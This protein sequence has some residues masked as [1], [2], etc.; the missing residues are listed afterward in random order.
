MRKRFWLG[1][2]GK[3]FSHKKTLLRQGN[4]PWAGGGGGTAPCKPYRYVPLQRVGFLRLFGLKTGIDCAHFN[5]ESGMVF[6]GTTEVY[7]HICSN[8][9]NDDIIS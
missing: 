4:S 9:S 1:Q 7:E 5:L 3:L 6:N 8:L 2:R